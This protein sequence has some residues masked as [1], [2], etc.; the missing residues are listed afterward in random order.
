MKTGEHSQ[1]HALHLLQEA[2]FCLTDFPS[3]PIEFRK[4][5]VMFNKHVDKV[6]VVQP[7]WGNL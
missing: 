4:N 6:E 5:M 1:I 2:L 3:N 7:V